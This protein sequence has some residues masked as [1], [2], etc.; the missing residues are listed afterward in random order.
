MNVKKF[1]EFINE[2]A[3]FTKVGKHLVSDSGLP[4]KALQTKDLDQ[5]ITYFYNKD[6]NIIWPAGKFLV[7]FHQDGWNKLYD[8][9]KAGIL[10]FNPA[11]GHISQFGSSP[12][13]DIW[14]KSYTNKIENSDMI[15][16]VLEGVVEK[17]YAYI[18]MMSVRAGYKRNSINRRMVETIEKQRP[19]DKIVWDEP[20]EDG[21]KF[22][23]AYHGDSALFFYRKGTTARPRNWSKLYP[24]GES[25]IYKPWEK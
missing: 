3:T 7:Y 8:E 1:N 24:D 12:I 2:M 15:Y 10:I 21:L 22:I 17:G 16:G 25:K 20:T 13:K 6:A 23:K 4:L 18:E 11:R 5:N 14:K 9:G 19:N